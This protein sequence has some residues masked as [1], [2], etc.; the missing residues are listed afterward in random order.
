MTISKDVCPS[1]GAQGVLAAAISAVGQALQVLRNVRCHNTEPRSKGG[2]YGMCLV[3]AVQGN[4][5]QLVMLRSPHLE[6]DPPYGDPGTVL[7]ALMRMV[8]DA[9]VPM[10]WFWRFRWC[11]SCS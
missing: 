9:D 6:I 2:L 7:A 3:F 5:Q 1:Q 10:W 4:K 11:G 8:L